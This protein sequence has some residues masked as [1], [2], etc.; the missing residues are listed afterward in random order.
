MPGPT[1]GGRAA[2]PPPP[3]FATLVARFTADSSTP[4]LT[5]IV[6]LPSALAAGDDPW[7]IISYLSGLGIF[8]CG[9]DD[10][11]RVN[12][13]DSEEELH[14]WPCREGIAVS[15]ASEGVWVLFVSRGAP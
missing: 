13:D 1:S 6:S 12:D 9:L 8:V 7:R 11:L 15:I 10:L 5:D 3:P 14:A 2:V 4:P